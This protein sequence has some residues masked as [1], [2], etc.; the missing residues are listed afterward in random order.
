MKILAIEKD[1]PGVSAE[2]FTPDLKQAEAAC[3]WTH[4]QAG[5]L[6]EIYFRQDQPAAVLVLECQDVD[7]AQ[8]ILASLPLVEAGLITFEIIPLAPYP[9]FA[10]LFADNRTISSIISLD[11]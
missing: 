7:E 5:A 1:A 8:Q 4:Y 6:R 11:G 3:A 10:R 2:E 9:G